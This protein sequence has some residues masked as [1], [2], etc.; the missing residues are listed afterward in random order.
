M[1]PGTV[2]R[3]EN[4]PY[5]RIGSEIKPRWF[6]YLGDT[7]PF[8]SPILAHL[9]TTT[10]QIQ[11]FQSGGKRAGHRYL[12]LQP[13]NTPFELEGLIDYDEGLHSCPK[14]DLS[15]NPEIQI[16][17]ELDAKILVSIYNGLA[18]SH[19]ISFQ[20]LMDIHTGLNKVGITGLKM[21]KRPKTR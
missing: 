11:D 13:T 20:V 3:W 10:T 17:G 9:C 2:F 5:P 14:K 19:S 21:P 18:S 1:K 16:K 8:F 4:F 15:E 12:P 7:G 6:I